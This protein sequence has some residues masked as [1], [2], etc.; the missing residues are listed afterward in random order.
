MAPE[1][2]R[3]RHLTLG[4]AIAFVFAVFALRESIATDP[5]ESLFYFC[6][7]PIV[8]VALSW[9]VGM[10]LAVAALSFG[11][12]VA[13]AA[14]EDADVSTLGF[15]AR[16]GAFF[17]VAL[18]VGFTSEKL[19]DALVSATAAERRLASVIETA[20]DALIS[21]DSSGAITA[22][23]PAAER[24]FGWPSN[25]AIGRKVADVVIPPYLREQHWEGLER[26]FATGEGPVIGKRIE[27]PGLH[28]DGHEF[29]VELTISAQ[30]SGDDW[31][32]NAFLHDISE[33][34]EAEAAREEADRI[35][36][37]FFALVSHELRT[38]LT[39]IVGYAELLAEEGDGSEA[40]S[41]EDRRRFVEVINRNGRRM[42]RLVGDL[43]FV[44]RLE[45]GRLEMEQ[46]EVDLPAIARQS[47]EAAMPHA[48]AGGVNLVAKIEQ[49]PR[50]HGDP[51]RI[52]QVFDNLVSNA[53]KFTPEGGEVAV[54]VSANEGSATIEVADTGMGIPAA[55]RERLFERFFRASSAQRSQT[56]GAGLGLV[57]T[58]AIVEG[59]GGSIGFESAEGEGTTFQITLPLAS[60]Q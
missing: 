13:W 44:A 18:L 30:R 49:V 37:E 39:S 52:G 15:L 4:V 14:I 34:K 40:L 51:G 12:F 23:N 17:P 29:A 50:L 11:L 59:H 21:M 22:W 1:S 33:R 36:D 58:K 7:L 10:G 20:H 3:G 60:H 35:K 56:P 31:S 26:F 25:E 2:A 27:V 45:A 8:L 6:V 28:R 42:L 43:L 55:D 9:G 46:A 24:L 19:R 32:F 47:V 53:I 5:N 54:R 57:I 38:P 48:R 41:D 16:A